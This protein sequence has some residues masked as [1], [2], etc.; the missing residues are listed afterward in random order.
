MD[1]YEA[2]M[3]EN[4]RLEKAAKKLVDTTSAHPHL[5]SEILHE[6]AARLEAVEAGRELYIYP[7]LRAA[8]PMPDL[9]GQYTQLIG[10]IRKA[11]E[12]LFA[13]PKDFGLVFQNQAEI[14]EKEITEM[15]QWELHEAH[16]ALQKIIHDEDA[17]EFG[18]RVY[19]EEL[20]VYH[21]HLV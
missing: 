6:I 19:D 2:I 1:M 17:A 20:R 4:R 12:E 8:T 7:Q 14:L 16:P 18:P 10:S 13:M 15:L 5:R 21:Q 11:L 9:M 3:A